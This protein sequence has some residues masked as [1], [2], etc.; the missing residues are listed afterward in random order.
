MEDL[1]LEITWGSAKDDG[2]AF[3]A[4]RMGSKRFFLARIAT[5]RGLVLPL[6][7]LQAFPESVRRAIADR[8]SEATGLSISDAEL[9]KF[10]A[11]PLNV[12]SEEDRFE[13]VFRSLQASVKLLGEQLR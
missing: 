13:A 11:V 2:R 5:H 12:I 10:P 6:A 9:A 3:A 4:V 1:D 7:T 8:W